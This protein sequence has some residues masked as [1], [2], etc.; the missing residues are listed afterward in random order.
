[1]EEK[2]K[3][4][5]RRYGEKNRP[6]QK[7]HL[8]TKWWIC[9]NVAEIEFR[10]ESEK[11]EIAKLCE[12]VECENRKSSQRIKRAKRRYHSTTK[13]QVSANHQKY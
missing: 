6:N 10:N 1:M 11:Y 9:K 4:L 5:K 2:A 8:H 3:E 7:M 12:N 13:R